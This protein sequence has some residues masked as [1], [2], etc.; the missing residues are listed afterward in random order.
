MFEV[1]T[2]TS[3]FLSNFIKA[4]FQVQCVTW[5]EKKIVQLFVAVA[6]MQQC[7][8]G[9]CDMLILSELWFVFCPKTWRRWIVFSNWLWSLGLTILTK[10]LMHI[11]QRYLGKSALTG[12]S[13]RCHSS[14][15][16]Y[17]KLFTSRHLCILLQ[18]S[19]TQILFAH[20]QKAY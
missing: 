1:G 10:P 5:H 7:R 18:V 16:F 3:V 8:N 2:V 12:I 9:C 20:T 19:K 13:S 17:L 14:S 15:T 11:Q 4:L 6:S